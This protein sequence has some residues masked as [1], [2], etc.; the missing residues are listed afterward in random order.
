MNQSLK[1]PYLESSKPF[2][3]Q[4]ALN[5]SEK[6]I[7]DFFAG[8]GGAS[9]G[10]EIG[11]NAP[12]FAAVNHNPKALSMHEANHPHAKHYVQDVFA[13]DPVE[14]CEG[15]KVGWFHASPDCTHH[16]QAAGGQ[17][18]KKEIRDLS[19][20]VL[21]VA[22][23]VRPDVISLENVKQILNWCPLIAKRDKATGRVV[24]LDR[25]NIKGKKSYRVAEPGEVV[26]RNN[27]FLVPNQ[28]LKGKTWRHFV[29]Q[30][31]KLGYVVEWKLLRAADYGAP[32]TRERLFL[33]AR[34]DGQPIVWPEPT[35]RSKTERSRLITRARKLPFWRTGAE[36]IDFT[37]LGK[38]I[39]GRPKP[40][41]DAT[42][43]RIARGLQKFVL[44]EKEPFFV[45]SATPF[46]S[47]DFGT[48]T[49][50]SI[51]EPLATV[52]STFGGHSALISPV[53]APF[54]T[55]FAN[56]SQ[57]RNWSI[58]EPLTTICAQ[59]KGGHHGLVAAYMMQANGGFC[60]TVG[61]SLNDPLST[62]TNTGSQQQLVSAVL[63]KE[64][65]NDALRVATFLINF[66][67]NGDARDIKAPLDTLTTKD[68]LALV[69]VWIKG[70]PWVIVDIRMRMLKPRELFR[71]QGFPDSY[72]IEHG[73]D[74]KPL[75]KTDQVFM[76]GNSVSPLPM[77]AI[78]RAN[79]PFLNQFDSPSKAPSKEINTNA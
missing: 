53:V 76:C 48:S 31:E 55:E 71:A 16:S 22:G 79:N 39:F 75:S 44:D 1:S 17:P 18:R 13:V 11:L 64:N 77:A 46:I 70:E 57:Q 9:T 7:I 34:C 41:A 5:F 28:K 40:L 30:L 38:S 33:I 37:D 59:V 42:L 35:H 52:T 2:K 74:G 21:K 4:F 19:W 54:F 29:K 56:A 69:T 12:V 23:K 60:E 65:L 26:P 68:R 25:I 15:H 43:R 32:T 8:G 72:V 6:I 20:V 45:E 66:Y 3:T 10:L 61:R 36:I 58:K 63:S 24:T 73:H 49:G 67:G 27:Q 47:R 50:H 78:A 14:I 62:I 51:D